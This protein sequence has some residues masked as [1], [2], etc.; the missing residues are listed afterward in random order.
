MCGRT[1]TFLLLLGGTD[2]AIDDAR[3]H[4][5]GDIASARKRGAGADRHS[6]HSGSIGAD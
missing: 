4:Y 1:E 3:G 5:R 6:I 2:E